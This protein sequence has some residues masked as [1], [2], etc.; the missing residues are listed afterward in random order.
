MHNVKQTCWMLTKT[1]VNMIMI[2]L[3]VQL[4][5]KGVTEI[6]SNKTRHS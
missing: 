2:I 3:N 4:G 6:L 1:I 5:F